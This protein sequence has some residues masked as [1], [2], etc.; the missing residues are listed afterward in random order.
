MDGA[1]RDGEWQGA[2]GRGGL[3]IEH[4]TPNVEGG[5]GWSRGIGLAGQPFHR[6]QESERREQASV[7]SSIK[8]RTV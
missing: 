1:G 2:R 8:R 3:N 6:E 4:P 7:E 5:K